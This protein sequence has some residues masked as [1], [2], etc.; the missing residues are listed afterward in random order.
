MAKDKI[1]SAHIRNEGLRM[2]P[3]AWCLDNADM[4]K[5]ELPK[6]IDLLQIYQLA[7]EKIEEEYPIGR[8]MLETAVEAL[9]SGKRLEPT[10]L[11]DQFK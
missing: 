3:H 1:D 9:E 6:L 10:K 5:V 8:H 7:L 4:L 2:T 11:L